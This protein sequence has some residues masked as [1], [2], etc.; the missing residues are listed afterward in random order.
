MALHVIMLEK[1]HAGV[2]GRIA[3][4]YPKNYS[5]SDVL[6]LVRTEDISSKVAAN[7]GLDG[8]VKDAADA[9]LKLNGAYSGFA[10]SALWE[11]IK[12]E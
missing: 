5:V 4:H 11:W 2:V 1:E 12:D 8:E 3:E 6:F 7:I 9:V 10:S